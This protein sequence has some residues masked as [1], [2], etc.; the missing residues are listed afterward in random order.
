MSRC[1]DCCL[2]SHSSSS[3]L[4]NGFRSGLA[5]NLDELTLITKIRMWGGQRERE[6]GNS[7][8]EA[9]S[10]GDGA[11]CCHGHNHAPDCQ[12]FGLV[13]LQQGT[14][15]KKPC[16]KKSNFNCKLS[17]RNMPGSL[18]SL[19]ACQHTS[20]DHQMPL[21]PGTEPSN[22]RPYRH[23]WE[24]ENTIERM[25][26]EMLDTGITGIVEAHMPLLLC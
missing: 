6:F 22:L 5:S 18:R 8:G 26:G 10:N 23:H 25:I 15:E 12:V 11:C 14:I 4:S 16:R 20:H 24:Q 3:R 17:A 21:I 9:W 13:H 1:K 2:L 19:R 7:G